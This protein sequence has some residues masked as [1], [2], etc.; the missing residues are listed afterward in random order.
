MTRSV[1]R[2]FAEKEVAPNAEER[3][4]TEQFE[5][6]LF[7][8]MGELGLTGIPIPEQYGGAG[9]DILT[10]AVVLESLSQVCASTAAV[11][12]AHTAFSAWPVYKFGSEELKQQ[13]LNDMACGVKLGACGFPAVSRDTSLKANGII[14]TAD[15]A[16]FVLN[17]ANSFV[18]NAGA[19][20]I[21]I[22]YA[23]LPSI[24]RKSSLSAFLIESGTPGCYIG[25][26]VR[27]L[28]LR[29]LMTAE[30]VFE[31]C[32]VAKKNRLGKEGQGRE[33]SG[34]VIDIGHI[35]AAAQ[36]VGIAQGALEAAAAYAKERMQ[37]G[38][39]IGRQ[40][41]ISFKL[42]DMSAKI[43]AARLLAYQASWRMS[44]GL[45]CSREAAIARK[46]AADTAVSAAIDAV[47][48]F[49][50]YGYMREYR[51]ERFLRDAKCLETD[52]GTGGMQTDFIYRIL[53]E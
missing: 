44:E 37:F 50:G 35:S 48:V 3:D 10:Y 27:K 25:N 46:F 7:G 32:K 18:I 24:S 34:S 33:I 21:Y 2:H 47:Q 13:Y 26:K 45:S 12:A 19:A 28:G 31:H 11:L 42:A 41:G 4:E 20:D 9:S 43:E 49:G 52:I 22:V 5:R 15:G 39:Q 30:L 23:Q 17:G 36:A 6:A 29:S 53:A 1:V 16:G 38:K 40:Q 8:R 14:A 51:M